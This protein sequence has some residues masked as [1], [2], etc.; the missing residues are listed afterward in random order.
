MDKRSDLEHFISEKKGPVK[1]V[2]QNC[3][4][5]SYR[6]EGNIEQQLEGKESDTQTSV[7]SCMGIKWFQPHDRMSFCVKL[8]SDSCLSVVL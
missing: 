7:Q 8:T 2:R 5:I 6:N 4:I 1:T 3:S